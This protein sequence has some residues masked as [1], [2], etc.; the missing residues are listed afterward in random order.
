MIIGYIKNW[1]KEKEQ[2]SKKIQKGMEY[3]LTNDFYNMA[4]GKYEI[5]SD[6]M[7]ALVQEYETYAKNEMKPESHEKYIDIQYVCS[8]EEKIGFGIVNPD[9]EILEELIEEKDIIFYK[10]NIKNEMDLILTEGMY[11][12]FGSSDI[13]RPCCQV[14]SSSRVKKVV[15]KIKK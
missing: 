6:N 11:A 7:Y 15:V 3:I 2:F 8:G 4:N 1:E 14:K 10:D 5:D 13:H 12:I 9:N